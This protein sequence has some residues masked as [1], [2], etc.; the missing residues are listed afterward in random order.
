MLP[1]MPPWFLPEPADWDA[2]ALGTW[3]QIS[4]GSVPVCQRHK[5][6]PRMN[7]P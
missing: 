5:R 6:N 1:K 4:L 7:K 3:L 2:S